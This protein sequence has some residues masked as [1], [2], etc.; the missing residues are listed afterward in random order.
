[1]GLVGLIRWPAKGEVVVVVGG[2]VEGLVVD[3]VGRR[4]ALRR[5]ALVMVSEISEVLVVVVL[6]VVGGVADVGVLTW[7]LEL[8]SARSFALSLSVSPLSSAAAW[9]WSARLSSRW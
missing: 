4:L 6:V 1:M 8:L 9:S 7:S 3:L 2:V 5:L